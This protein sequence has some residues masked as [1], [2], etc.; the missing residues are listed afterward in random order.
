MFCLKG[1]IISILFVIRIVA[2]DAV[3]HAY[4]P[5]ILNLEFG[6]FLYR[7][8][9]DGHMINWLKMALNMPELS[10]PRHLV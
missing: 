9:I 10:M 8:I 2:I 3:F 7:F 6:F 5:I 1:V 4:Y